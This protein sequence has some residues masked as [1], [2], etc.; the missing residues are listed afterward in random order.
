M[1]LL[2]SAMVT[3]VRV[4]V[5]GIGVASVE[6]D[7]IGV[8]RLVVAETGS[9]LGVAAAEDEARSRGSRWTSTR[10]CNCVD[11]AGSSGSACGGF[12]G[13]ARG[14]AA[15]D[16]VEDNANTGARWCSRTRG[17]RAVADRLSTAMSVERRGEAGVMATYVDATQSWA[18]RRRT[19]PW[20]QPQVRD[21]VRR[22]AREN[23]IAGGAAASAVAP[24]WRALRRDAGHGKVE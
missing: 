17:S 8:E 22:A 23:G 12:R 3:S 21:S 2:L 13:C 6:H 16:N 20:A 15:T 18:R 7:D 9:G 10:W 1:Q 5:E 14:D 11:V 24:A 19:A 4:E